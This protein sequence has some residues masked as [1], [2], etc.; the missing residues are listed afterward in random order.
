M[1][2]S[3][4]Q[5]EKMLLRTALNNNQLQNRLVV[6]LT[7]LHFST[8]TNRD[9]FNLISDNVNQGAYLNPDTAYEMLCSDSRIASGEIPAEYI[10]KVEEI[11]D[12]TKST[13]NYE[14]LVKKLRDFRNNEELRERLATADFSMGTDEIIDYLQIEKYKSKQFSPEVTTNAELIAN[15]N[16]FIDE[17]NSKDFKDKKII[18]GIPSI[19]NK[20]TFMPSET[21]LLRAEP[22]TGKTILALNMFSNN[23]VRNKNCILFSLEMSFE[24]M[25][26]DMANMICGVRADIGRGK[27]FCEEVLKTEKEKLLAFEKRMIEMNNWAIVDGCQMKNKTIDEIIAFCNYIKESRGWDKIDYV[28]IDYLQRIA[29]ANDKETPWQAQK[30]NLV[31]IQDF[32][33]MEDF[34]LTMIVSLN[35]SGEIKGG[36]DAAFDADVILHLQKSQD[37]ERIL[38]L[39]TLKNRHGEMPRIEL[40]RED[41][42]LRFKSRG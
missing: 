14:K 2:L 7:P 24:E 40:M 28:I 38:E 29:P 16:A 18:S 25:F 22:G 8:K 42:S 30:N 33:A 20:F 26:S 13:G 32:G 35:A 5:T 3:R 37:C 27:D 39:K 9:M 31:K 15:Y 10:I 34:F 36:T 23:V 19:D 1:K 17:V 11:V 21:M 41:G 6:D 12:F 4:E